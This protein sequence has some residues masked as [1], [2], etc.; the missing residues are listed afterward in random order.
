M[1]NEFDLCVRVSIH[2]REQP[3]SGLVVEETAVV[4]C[5]TFLEVAAVLAEFHKLTEAIKKGQL[6]KK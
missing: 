2:S 1:S 6:E 3:S 5:E 4:R